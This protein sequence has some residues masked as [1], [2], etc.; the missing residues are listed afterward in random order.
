MF[1]KTNIYRNIFANISQ[2]R[3]LN[4]LKVTFKKEYFIE[5]SN[6]IVPPLLIIIKNC[7]DKSWCFLKLILL[8]HTYGTKIVL[9][10]K[11]GY[12]FYHSLYFLPFFLHTALQM[13]FLLI[14]FLFILVIFTYFSI[15]KINT[16][17]KF[18]SLSSMVQLLFLASLHQPFTAAS[19][20]SVNLL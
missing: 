6:L 5:N 17:K 4:V 18:L 7:N 8:F 13:I 11:K 14:L 12:L 2:Q 15:K 19:M 1:S 10:T 20:D 3:L 9:S 16:A